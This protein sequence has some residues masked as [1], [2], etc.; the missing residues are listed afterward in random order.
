M[1]VFLS[2]FYYYVP[3][4]IFHR[5]HVLLL[6]LVPAGATNANRIMCPPYSNF[7]CI[8]VYTLYVCCAVQTYFVIESFVFYGVV[9]FQPRQF[10]IIAEH[11][12]EK[13]L[14]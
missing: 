11:D 2:L 1:N 5:K 14:R 7:H 12:V 3:R 8:P 9:Q 4:G 6:M 10:N 13:K